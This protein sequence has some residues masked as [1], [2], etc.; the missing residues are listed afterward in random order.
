MIDEPQ[1]DKHKA[2]DGGDSTEELPVGEW[3]ARRK[4]SV[5]PESAAY[6]EITL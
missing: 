2:C 6:V 5:I 1:V 4:R 3:R